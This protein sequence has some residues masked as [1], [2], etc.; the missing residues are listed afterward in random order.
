VQLNLGGWDHCNEIVSY[1]TKHRLT[2][3]EAIE[4][5]VTVGLSAKRAD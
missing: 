1:A 5:L 4:D 2:V 3:A